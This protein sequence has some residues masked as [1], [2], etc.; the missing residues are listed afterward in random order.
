M[1][2]FIQYLVIIYN[3]KESKKYKYLN[4]YMSDCA[5]IYVC[6]YKYIYIYITLLYTRHTAL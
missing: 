2:N 1:G 5:Y 4:T 6:V 3:G